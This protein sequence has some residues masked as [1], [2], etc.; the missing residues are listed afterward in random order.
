M[1]P[2][3]S[4]S[5]DCKPC[6]KASK[7]T[8][9]ANA[10]KAAKTTLPPAGYSS[11][12]CL[13]PASTGKNT[14]PKWPARSSNTSR[15]SPCPSLSLRQGCGHGQGD[16]AGRSGQPHCVDGCGHGQGDAEQGKPGA[17]PLG[18]PAAQ[19][20]PGWTA[21][22]RRRSTTAPASTPL[23][24]GGGVLMRAVG[25]RNRWNQTESDAIHAGDD[26]APDAKAR[27]MRAFSWAML[28]K[29]C[30]RMRQDRTEHD[31]VQDTLFGFFMKK[32]GL[33]CDSGR[34]EN[35]IKAL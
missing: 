19:G 8:F 24:T 18:R 21:A 11:A 3:Y 16:A 1:P 32:R 29:G 7:A 15:V 23:S 14:L 13:S 5:A 20:A 30:I 28:G 2:Q 22:T 33:K 25:D 12:V 10:L 9:A 34:R 17:E 27:I 26:T 4:T 31:V 6:P 35:C